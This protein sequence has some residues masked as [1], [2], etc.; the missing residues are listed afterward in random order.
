[1]M[2]RPTMTMAAA[3]QDDHGEL[4]RSGQD[5]LDDPLSLSSPVR[6]QSEPQQSPS[7]A[8]YG[9]LLFHRCKSALIK[10]FSF[11]GPGFMIA[12]AYSESLLYLLRYGIVTYTQPAS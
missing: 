2:P 5:Q 10:F 6:S 8:G 11:I 4:P 7:T 1:M 3:N 9:A 12:V